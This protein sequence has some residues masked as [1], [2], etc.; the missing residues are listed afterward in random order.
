MSTRSDVRERGMIDVGS[1]R[2]S[3]ADPEGLVELVNRVAGSH[4]TT[5]G[6]AS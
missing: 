5:A 6:G 3:L 4:I 2:L 1:T